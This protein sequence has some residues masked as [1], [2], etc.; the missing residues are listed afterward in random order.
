MRAV[1]VA[2][3]LTCA[4][5][6]PGAAV[7]RSELD[8]GDPGVHAADTGPA[9]GPDAGPADQAP[10]PPRYTAI[11]L[12][13]IVGGDIPAATAMTAG[14][15]F[16]V[17]HIA[18]PDTVPVCLNVRLLNLHSHPELTGR[19]AKAVNSHG[20]IIAGRWGFPMYDWVLD[21]DGDVQE[22][23]KIE[24]S[25]GTIVD[26]WRAINDRG[27]ILGNTNDLFAVLLRDGKFT[28][29]PGNTFASRMNESSQI[30][31]SAGQDAFSWSDGI[32][33]ILRDPFG[34]SAAIAV[35]DAG[36][37][38]GFRLFDAGG[39]VTRESAFFWD[40]ATF[41]DLGRTPVLAGAES[42]GRAINNRGEVIGNGSKGG[43]FLYSH[44]VVY[45]IATLGVLG[46]IEL[47]FPISID[48]AG[49]ILALAYDTTEAPLP[50][51][52]ISHLVAL[53]REH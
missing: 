50:N 48:D 6:K 38:A 37:I 14:G 46:P 20:A 42:A 43:M 34:S 39:Y 15:D 29:L 21:V 40:G 35:N 16:C 25:L 4:C 11:D 44:G 8:A 23:P 53:Y 18:K 26:D 31:G 45:D 49:D 2:F 30:V 33:T 22:L 17:S 27:D 1:L 13:P 12:T 47:Y 41:H 52:R 32:L 51:G 24:R 36:E 3:A 9:S 5:E 7:S 19:I 28:F 10:P